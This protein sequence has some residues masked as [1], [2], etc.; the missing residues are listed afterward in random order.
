V[1][2]IPVSVRADAVARSDENRVAQPPVC[3]MAAP[4]KA[5]KRP[6]SRPV[7]ATATRSDVRNYTNGW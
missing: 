5:A 7:A 2:D 4:H 6:Y 3:T 1:R